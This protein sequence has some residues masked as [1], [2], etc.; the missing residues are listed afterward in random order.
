V[1]ALALILIFAGTMLGVV[2]LAVL[3]W[4]IYTGYLTRVERRLARRKGVYRTLVAELASR[5]RA[6]LDPEIHRMGTLLDLEAL[7]AVLEEQARGTAERPAWLLDVYDRLGLVDKYVQKL[8]TARQWRERA[9]AAELLGRV[10]NAKAV[11]VLLETVQATR[12]ED[13]DVREIA[14]RALARIADPRAVEPLVEALKSS[15]V[16]LAPRIAD[17]LTRHGDLVVDPLIAFLDQPGRHPARAWAANVLGE[18]RAQ[19]AFPALARGLG[20]LEDEV[21]AKSATAIGRLGDRRAIAYLLEHLLSD[22]APFVRARIAGTLGQFDDPEVIDR[23]V[24]GLGDPAWW[25]RMRSVEAL[26]QIGSTAEGPLLVALDDPDPEIRIRAAVALERLNVPAGLVGMIQRGERVPEAM[27]TLVK[28]ATAGARE[29]LAELLL[30]PAPEVRTAV[31]SAIRRAARRDLAPELA[32]AGR[33]DADPDVRAA[34]FDALRA[35]GALEAVPHALEGMTDPDERVRSAAITLLGSL[36]G[37]EAVQHLRGRVGDPEAA[38]RVA[39]ARALGLLRADSAV[40]DFQRL[41]GD[42]RS[43]VREA[44]ARGAAEAGARPLVPAL[45]DL[46]GD[47]DAAVQLAAVEALGTLRDPAAVP[48]LVRTFAGAGPDLREAIVEAI[49][50]LDVATVAGLVDVLVAN[51]DTLGKLGAI[52][53]LGRMQSPAVASVIDR[54]WQDPEPAVRAAAL[55]AFG[56][57]GGEVAS[58]PATAGLH[59]PADAVRAA[60]AD[61]CARLHLSSQGPVVL[62]LLQQD[63]SPLVRERAALA[64]GL[65][66]VPGGEAALAAVCHRDE[67]VDVRA[68]AALASGAFE[69]TSIVARVVE[70]TD[71]AAVREELRQRLKEDP[72]ARLLARKLSPARHLELRSLGAVASDAAERSLAEGMRSILDSGERIRLI[73][74]LRAFQGEQSR[75]ALL[76]VI[77]GDPSPEV[78]TAALTAISTLLQGD[79]LLALA[80]RALGDPSLLVR[81]A[82]VGLFAGIPPERGLPSLLQTLRA[83][84]DPA[85]LAAV[86]ER[87]EAAFPS[88]VDLAL[89]LP[90]DGPEATLV[91]RVARYIH[92]PELPRLL[93]VMARSGSPEVRE[94]IAA[95]W[96]HRADVVD[97]ASLEALVLDPVASVRRVAAG[98]AGAAERWDL[99]ARMVE[100]PDPGVRHEVGLVLGQ[101]RHLG[102]EGKAALE[103][104]SGDSETTVRAAAYV[105]WLLQGTPLPLPPGLDLQAVA[106]SLAAIADRAGLREAAR[107]EPGEDRRLSAALALALLQDDVAREVARTDPVPTIRHRVSGTLELAAPAVT[108]GAR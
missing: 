24:R 39:V 74:G 42:P 88:F 56:R 60:A 1:T 84:D 70:M 92:H 26:E 107:T 104:L 49:G 48:S 23:L 44:G 98:A 96:S 75:G 89:G 2:L 33:A 21:R 63:P 20:D 8:R 27:E 61:A 90:L 10:G 22:P 105:G 57:I 45:I 103:R 43:E 82:A 65:L 72:L 16:W 80:E 36:G 87:A 69:E 18:V 41:L 76:Q 95:L 32:Q 68:A 59:D 14:L 25:V 71:Q 102:A 35:L 7:E 55:E 46:L 30:H 108:G 5:E 6:L 31:I 3:A 85:V 4:F 13:G 15:E 97:A 66:R 17:I 101:A 93:P 91:A 29:L 47:S 54:L 73:S 79:E 50:R 52:R 77:R 67:P 78:R 99:L 11:P 40:A 34:A 86:A 9:F 51:R 81:R 62:G 19:R 12:T 106:A 64:V 94:A 53:T 38:V 37:P 58:G 83:D 28:F 100:D